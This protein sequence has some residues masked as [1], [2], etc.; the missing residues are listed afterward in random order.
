VPTVLA[1]DQGTTGST[2]LLVGDGGEIVGRGYREIHQ[3]YP[4]PGWVE[5][6]PEEI[7]QATLAAAR[8][9]LG[10]EAPAAIG[11]TNQRETVI[12]WERRTGR[13]VHR[14]LVW[15]DRRT[16]ERCR[17][18]RAAHG[19]AFVVERTGLVW[20]P[21]FSA[22]KIEWL[23]REVPGLRSRV[24]RGDVVFGTVDSW[25]TFRLTGGRAH[26]TDPT[27][28][29]RTLL[30]NIST[31][32]WDAE[33]LELFGV[34]RDALPTLVPSSGVV[35]TADR[36]ALG[37]AAPVA[38]MAG[39]QQAALFGQGCY[40]PGDSKN[41]YGTGAFL[42]MVVDRPAP[43]GQGVLTTMACDARGAPALAV[44]GAIFI[45][46]AAVQ[47]LRDGLGLI[48]TAA[49]TE[50]FARSVPDTGGVYFV[51]AL[52]GLG[53]PHWEPD[54]RGT[55]VGLTRGTGR[56]HL[57]RAALE[58]MAYSTREVAEA[59]AAATGVPL[60]TLKV[61]GGA[62][63][64]DWLM[65]FQADVLAAPVWRPDA[66][67]STGLG[68]AGLAGLAA[69][70]W[71]DAATF[72]ATRRYQAFSPGAGREDARFREWVRAVATTIHWAHLGVAARSHEDI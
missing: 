29:S 23:L 70:V 72:Q 54:A 5:H 31:R 35:G 48:A 27:N 1:L 17:A 42:L 9:A 57:V 40:Q 32:D 65:Q 28:A 18:L 61:D 16:A 50:A 46:G 62:A 34:P 36:A 53:A 38:G 11:I 37:V 58:A 71:A 21:Y 3:Y 24:D 45:A 10:S 19:D 30:Y 66:V 14:A 44:E 4:A 15:Q 47:W 43:A 55:I 13:P 20:D 56:A 67:E 64:N 63:A 8:D 60:R 52:V 69:G 59:M 68:A 7:W 25:L 26:V 39:D 41:T 6:D 49:D 33:L 51:P 2:A 22:T 12:A